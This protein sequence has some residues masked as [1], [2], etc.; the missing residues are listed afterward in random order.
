[1]F[2]AEDYGTT[3]LPNFEKYS[4]SDTAPYLPRLGSLQQD[5]C[6]TLKSCIIQTCWLEEH[7]NTD[8]YKKKKPVS[9]FLAQLQTPFQ[10]SLTKSKHHVRIKDINTEQPY[11][12]DTDF[13]TMFA[14]FWVMTSHIFGCGCQNFERTYCHLLPQMGNSTS[15]EKF[16]YVM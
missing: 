13:Y 5:Y 15:H 4:P 6:K 12:R 2:D 16:S 1:L 11:H 8:K 14:V 10:N 9:T 7:K 3:T